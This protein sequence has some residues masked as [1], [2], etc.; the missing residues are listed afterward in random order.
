MNTYGTFLKKLFHLAHHDTLTGLPNRLLFTERLNQAVTQ[1][2][3][4]EDMIGL[5][6]IDMDRFKSIN[7]TFGHSLR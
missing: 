6:L 4:S 3:R 5:M 2:D 1:A 7:D